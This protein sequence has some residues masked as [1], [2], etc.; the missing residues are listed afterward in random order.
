ML[1]FEHSIATFMMGPD[2]LHST[3]TD[4]YFHRQLFPSSATPLLDSCFIFQITACK[5]EPACPPPVRQVHR[6]T[7]SRSRR[8]QPECRCTYLTSSVWHASESSVPA[9]STQA[10]KLLFCRGSDLKLCGRATAVCCPCCRR[11]RDHD[12]FRQHRSSKTISSLVTPPPIPAV[13]TGQGI[14]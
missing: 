6:R 5:H 11:C 10:G 13:A 14:S 7:R 1:S 9:K 8:E 3:I 12:C 4:N 2:G